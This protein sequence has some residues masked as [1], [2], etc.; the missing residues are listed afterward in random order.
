MPITDDNLSYVEANAPE[1]TATLE[2]DPETSNLAGNLIGA[3]EKVTGMKS[4]P[5]PYQ[6]KHHG[7]KFVLNNIS[8][9][10]MVGGNGLMTVAEVFRNPTLALW[11]RY[12]QF[13][14]IFIFSFDWRGLPDELTP[15]DLESKLI[16][17]GTVAIIS[18]EGVLC[19][20]NYTT[21]KYN[22][23]NQ[24]LV[25]RVNENKSKKLH[26]REFSDGE[27]V[28]INHQPSRLGLFN[29]IIPYLAA[30]ENAFYK[31]TKN[32][33]QS[34]TH[35]LIENLGDTA[36]NASDAAA[37]ETATLSGQN[38]HL[39]NGYNPAE[40]KRIIDRIDNLQ[41]ESMHEATLMTLD[42][43]ESL[44]KTI[45][46]LNIDFTK[47]KERL[48]SG[49]IEN[50]QALTEQASIM[51]LGCRTIAVAKINQTFKVNWSVDLNRPEVVVEE[52]GDEDETSSV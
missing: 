5:E 29:Q 49:E 33:S 6:S 45:I 27:F 34:G 35:L 9:A 21:V 8:D 23:Y 13:E 11:N 40:D 3:F 51:Y 10:T 28:I 31:L 1:N 44:I 46:G 26:M 48:V 16:R 22:I 41:I 24:P 7:D 52:E 12:L 2:T 39:V 38:V 30:W 18:V 15:I 25:I 47:K 20:V 4:S 50:S 37:L 32:T 43:Y 19:A 17:N 42:Y 14:N 36:N